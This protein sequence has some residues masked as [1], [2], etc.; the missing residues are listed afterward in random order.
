MAAADAKKLWSDANVFYLDGNTALWSAAGFSLEEG[1]PVALCAEDDTWYL[2]YK[3]PNA[4]KEVMEDFFDWK[5]SLAE[6]IRDGSY[7]Y[8]LPKGE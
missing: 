5:H 8:K 4:S 2:P 7:A 1:M 6:Q 3:G